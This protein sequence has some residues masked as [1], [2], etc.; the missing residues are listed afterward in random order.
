MSSKKVWWQCE[1]IKTHEW[2]ATIS[3]RT[4][5][6]GKKNKQISCVYCSGQKVGEDNNLLFKFLEVAKEWHPTKNGDKKPQD[7]TSGSNEKFWW[8]CVK[9]HEWEA[10]I[11]GRSSGSGCPKCYKES[12]K[13]TI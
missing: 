6:I 10:T 9:D 12:R 2:E 4:N 13:I 7:Y 1:K 5:R 3:N 8:K 11:W